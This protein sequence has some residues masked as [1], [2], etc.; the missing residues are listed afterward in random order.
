MQAYPE[1]G[2]AQCHVIG[3]AS[4]LAAPSNRRQVPRIPEV[5]VLP[6]DRPLVAGSKA[7]PLLRHST[8][9]NESNVGCSAMVILTLPSMQRR[10]VYTVASNWEQGNTLRLQV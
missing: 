7:N 9:A 6:M 3:V 8:G 2:P 4:A 1:T 5:K 10:R